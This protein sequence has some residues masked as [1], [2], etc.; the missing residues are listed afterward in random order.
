MYYLFKYDLLL[1]NSIGINIYLRQQEQKYKKNQ[2]K[3]AFVPPC[4][5]LEIF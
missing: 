5:N 4:C 3:V 1:T 2:V